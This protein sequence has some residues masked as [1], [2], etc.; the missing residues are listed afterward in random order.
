[1]DCLK[2]VDSVIDLGA[3]LEHLSDPCCGAQLLFSGVVR[4]QNVGQAVNGVSYEAFP[5]LANQVLKELAQEARSLVGSPL[6]IAILHRTGFLK[7][8]EISTVVA[9][10]TPHRD[11]S[12][13]ASRFLIEQLKARLPVWKE[14]R[15]SDGNSEWLDG[16]ELEKS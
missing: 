11:A 5:A 2:I 3:V 12:Y 10:A 1:M 7:V 6:R 13:T 16:N 8:G 9:V 14:E 4:N 15:Y